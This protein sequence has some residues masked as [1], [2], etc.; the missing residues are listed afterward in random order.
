MRSARVVSTDIERG[1]RRSSLPFGLGDFRA[2]VGSPREDEEQIG[3]PIDVPHEPRL[4]QGAQTDDT[5]LGTAAHRASDMQCCAAGRTTRQDE[6]AERRQLGFESINQRLQTHDVRI[7]E[8]SLPG[9]WD[10]GI[11]GIGEVGP[12]GE[13][14]L[15]DSDEHGI[16]IGVET[17]STSETHPR[18]QLID[19][20]VCIDPG[21][22]FAHADAT[23]QR[24]LAVIAGA[25]IDSH[26]CR[27]FSLGPSRDGRYHRGVSR[28]D[29]VHCARRT[30]RKPL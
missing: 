18:V 24:C 6:A 19:L 21:I 12:Q 14:I 28:P 25:R 30:R 8:R 4:G 16:K 13:E 15:L 9:T 2:V 7:S 22:R 20:T 27:S 5:T 26:V 11:G 29:Y 1:V 3:K 17:R 23:E 10:H